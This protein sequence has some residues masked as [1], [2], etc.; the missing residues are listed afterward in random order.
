[1]KQIKPKPKYKKGQPITPSTK[2]G[3][4]PLITQIIRSAKPVIKNTKNKNL[5][6]VPKLKLGRSST[7]IIIS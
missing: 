7:S 1:M 4:T 3:L 6:Y 5:V 2:K